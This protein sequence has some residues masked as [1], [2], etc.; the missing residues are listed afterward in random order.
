MS[1]TVH[2]H[3]STIGLELRQIHSLWNGN[4][5]LEWNAIQSLTHQFCSNCAVMN[6]RLNEG[7][8]VNCAIIWNE[9]ITQIFDNPITIHTYIPFKA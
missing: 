8:N 6:E 3:Q 1:Q 7:Y 5:T 4:E 9:P 2:I